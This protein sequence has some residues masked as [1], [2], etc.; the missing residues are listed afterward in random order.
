MRFAYYF[1]IKSE[2][3]EEITPIKAEEVEE[4]EEEQEEEK[5]GLAEITGN[6]IGAAG[7]NPVVGFAIIF[8]IIIIG[9]SVY[10]FITKKQ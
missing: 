10:Y 8:A 9:V 7:A 4:E 2:K 3:S 1:A 5:E 6:V